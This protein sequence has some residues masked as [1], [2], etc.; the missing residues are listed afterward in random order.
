[1]I[2]NHIQCMYLPSNSCYCIPG[3]IKHTSRVHCPVLGCMLTRH[4]ICFFLAVCVHPML[5]TY[6]VAVACCIAYTALNLGGCTPRVHYYNH[7]YTCKPYS[8][9]CHTGVWGAVLGGTGSRAP[10]GKHL[11]CMHPTSTSCTVVLCKQVRLLIHPPSRPSS[12]HPLI[13]GALVQGLPGGVLNFG[14]P[15]RA[16]K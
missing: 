11:T 3:D 15:I 13:R 1:M 14:D 8:I 9:G 16:S 7:V 5:G 2:M 4:I 12:L 6:S 10:Q